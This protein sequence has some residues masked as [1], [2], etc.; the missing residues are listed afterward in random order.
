MKPLYPNP[1]S[2]L[3][4]AL[5][6]ACVLG[7]FAQNSANDALFDTAKSG[8]VEDVRAAIKAGADVNA[9]KNDGTSAL[10]VAAKSNEKLGVVETLVEAGADVNARGENG[11]TALMYAAKNCENADIIKAI[12]SA[13]GDKSAKDTDGKKI[14]DYLSDNE[15]LRATDAYWEIRD[16]LY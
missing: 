7:A 5:L 6:L 10:I 11:W 8:T 16:L 4:C 14:I 9:R 13:G 12:I 2:A 15:K 1:V 3:R